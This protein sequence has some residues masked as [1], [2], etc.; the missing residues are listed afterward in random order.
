MTIS[1][2][3]NLQS[4]YIKDKSSQDIFKESGNRARSMALIHELVYQ[5]KDLKRIDFGNYIES[6]SLQLFNTYITDPNQIKLKINVDNILL[7]IKTTVPLG[8]I[9]NELMTNCL[10]HAFPDSKKGEINVEFHPKNDI[11]ELSVKDNGIGFPDYLNFQ[12]T[13]TLGLQI[14]NGLNQQIDGNIKLDK[15]KGTKIIITFKEPK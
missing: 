8:L 12:N 15:T 10:K 4:R 9:L 7:N 2:L 1:S 14:V 11:Y 13:D 5:S 6:L 3:L